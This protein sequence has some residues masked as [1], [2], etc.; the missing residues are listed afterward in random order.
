MLACRRSVPQELFQLMVTKA[1]R[2]SRRRWQAAVADVWW[3][4]CHP[5][6]PAVLENL[7]H[8]NPPALRTANLGGRTPQKY[9]ATL[10]N[11]SAPFIALLTG[12]TDALAER[13]YATLAANVH[14]T[15][16]ISHA[17]SLNHP[18][19]RT[20]VLVCLKRLTI[21]RLALEDLGFDP[22]RF[23]ASYLS[24][25]YYKLPKDTWSVIRSYL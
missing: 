12:V 19:A 1:K 21:A 25:A 17:I 22:T 20:S 8:D 3:A 10:N 15:L 2:G 16:A 5:P 24:R 23:F 13:D 14:T 6:N 18:L 11:G 7:I 9:A 4:A